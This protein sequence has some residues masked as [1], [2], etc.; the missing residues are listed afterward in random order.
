[1]STQN[2][3]GLDSLGEFATEQIPMTP[4]VNELQNVVNNQKSAESKY[5]KIQT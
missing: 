5:R 2:R 4:T 3:E 1:M